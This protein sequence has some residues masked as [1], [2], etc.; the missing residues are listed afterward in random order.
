MHEVLLNCGGGLR[1]FVESIVL[2]TR[3]ASGVERHVGLPG[4]QVQLLVRRQDG[5]PSAVDAYVIGARSR[6]RR[7]T[8]VNSHPRL[9]V[10]FRPGA[11]RLFLGVPLCELSD[12]VLTIE[13][14]WGDEGIR[15]REQL[16]TTDSLGAQVRI[17]ERALLAR[18]VQA[19]GS[20]NAAA[21]T[22][23]S[24]ARL[25]EQAQPLPTVSSLARQLG[26]S[27]RGLRRAFTDAAG[28]APKTYLRILR[29]R[30]ALQSAQADSA[31][32][33]SA[34]AAAAGYY[35]QAHMIDEF[36][37]L[38]TATPTRLLEEIGREGI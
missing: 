8:I 15:M 7:K 35:D 3:S 25:L 1:N 29:F 12:R 9:A 16:A 18:L 31:P 11:A 28:I 6:V 17:L 4:A 13:D 34:V 5:D 33:W 14:L 38:V 37:D 30:S 20:D 23:R 21:H 10:R 19:Y 32:R 2:L 36:Q 22:V 26:I 24:A 27:E